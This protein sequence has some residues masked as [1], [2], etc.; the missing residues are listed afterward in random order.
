MSNYQSSEA[1]EFYDP[2]NFKM[3]NSQFQIITNYF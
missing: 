3:I 2:L 1:E